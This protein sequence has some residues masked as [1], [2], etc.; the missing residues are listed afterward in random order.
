M[1][2]SICSTT[3]VGIQPDPNHPDLTYLARS[4]KGDR[5]YAVTATTCSCPWGTHN[6]EHL[7]D[8]PCRHVRDLRNLLD[9]DREKSTD[10]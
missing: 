1:A 4:S 3:F 6:R 7:L 10:D 8:K 9:L 5:T 2:D